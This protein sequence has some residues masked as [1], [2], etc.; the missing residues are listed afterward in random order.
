MTVTDAIKQAKTEH[1]VYSLLMAYVEALGHTGPSVPA[2][3]KRLPIF[4]KADVNE[5]LDVLREALDSPVSSRP[6]TRPL[7]EEAAEVFGAAS[8]QL[9]TL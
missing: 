5:R 7:I 1:V 4:A 8:E 9:Q 6:E 3:V 2:P